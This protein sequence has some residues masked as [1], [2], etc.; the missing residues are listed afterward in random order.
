MN[1][2][3]V[4][5]NHKCLFRYQNHAP[6]KAWS[7]Q[8]KLANKYDLSMPPFFTRWK[9]KAFNDSSLK[10]GSRVLVFCCG[11]G[12]DFPH[13]LRKIDKDGEIVGVNFSS[14]MLNMKKEKI[15]RGQL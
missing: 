6:T 8:P 13:I 11:T 5:N 4:R 1:H 7:R 9:Q 10:S 12:F 3:F 15:R 14:E 2:H